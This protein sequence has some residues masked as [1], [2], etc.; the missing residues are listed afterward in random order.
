MYKPKLA[1]KEK[2]TVCDKKRKMKKLVLEGVMEAATF[3]DLCCDI[4]VKKRSQP[5][6]NPENCGSNFLSVLMPR[7]KRKLFYFAQASLC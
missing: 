4:F 2:K 5:N 1:P 6:K 3:I 7:K